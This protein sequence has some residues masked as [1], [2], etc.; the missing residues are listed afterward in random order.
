[1]TC[2]LVCDALHLDEVLSIEAL[3]TAVFILNKQGQC[4]Y[5]NLAA[6]ELLPLAFLSGKKT[7]LAC[8]P[9]LEP[10]V[11]KAFFDHHANTRQLSIEIQKEEGVA[12][13]VLLLLSPLKNEGLLAECIQVDHQKEQNQNQEWWDQAIS[14]KEMV[15]HLAHEIKNPLGGIRGAAQLLESEMSDLELQQYTQIIIQES[16][17][18]QRL[19]D[20]LLLPHRYAPH[21]E[22]VNIHELIEH[23]YSLLKAQYQ[24]KINWIKDYDTS[25][26]ELMA[27]KEK[28]IQVILNIAQNAAQM[29]E[30]EKTKNPTITFRTRIARQVTIGKKRHKL[31]LELHVIDNGPGVALEIK[32]KVFFPLVSKRVGGDG[33]GLTLAQAYVFQHQGLITFDHTKEGTDFKIWIPILPL[34]KLEKEAL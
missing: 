27:D 3:S 2:T 4:Q 9:S 10:D 34:D 8:V 17:R 14:H 22:N 11:E 15:R 16:D 30:Q 28:L 21:L 6:R 31:V 13:S 20:R 24:D 19:V 5:A 26:P 18:L 7:L 32:D 12:V 1:M 25:L 33:L 23:V 29:L